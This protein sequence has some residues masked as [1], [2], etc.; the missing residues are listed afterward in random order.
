MRPRALAAEDE[1]RDVSHAR[2]RDELPR[3]GSTCA[4]G[5]RRTSRRAEPAMEAIERLRRAARR[6]RS[7]WKS[8]EASRAASAAPGPW[9]SP[10]TTRI[11][12][13]SRRGRHAQASPHRSSPGFG[14]DRPAT[15]SAGRRARPRLERARSTARG[16]AA[17]PGR[18]DVE[19]GRR[20]PDG[21]QARAGRA[22][23][24]VAVPEGRVDDCRCPAR[25]RAPG[26]P[27]R[28]VS[29]S[30]RARPRISPPPACLT[31]FVAASVTTIA[32]RPTSV[33]SNPRVAARAV[34]RRRASATAL[35]SS[36]PTT[37]GSA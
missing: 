34:A 12:T 3:R 15:R 6:P 13:P 9:P 24:R 14:S 29:R 28:S 7:S 16:R 8:A 10:S 18:V 17:G 1:A 21:A 5:R 19:L 23:R 31:R 30:R 11:T 27:A 25:D 36:T 4:I 33:S 37:N 20:A 32:T 35:G 2:V 26:S 22:G